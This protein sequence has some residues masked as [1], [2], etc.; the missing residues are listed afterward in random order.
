MKANILIDYNWIISPLS[1]GQEYQESY[2]RYAA[3]VIDWVRQN[4]HLVGLLAGSTAI[5]KE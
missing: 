5:S 1:L 2:W 4:W 3:I